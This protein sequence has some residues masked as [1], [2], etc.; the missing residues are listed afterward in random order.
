MSTT[1]LESFSMNKAL[2]GYLKKKQVIPSDEEV[3]RRLQA[4][5]ILQ[6]VANRWCMVCSQKHFGHKI[7]VSNCA[8]KIMTTGSYRLGAFN[9]GSDIDTV[10]VCPSHLSRTD[11]WDNFLPMLESHP[12]VKDITPVRD[13]KVPIIKCHIKDIDIDILQ[14]VTSMQYSTES[15]DVLDD[16]ILEAMDS[17][18]I[19]SINGVRHAEA[20]LKELPDLTRYQL[21]LRAVKQWAKARGILNNAMGYLNGV[22]CAIMAA[23]VAKDNPNAL[24][25]VLFA[26]FFKYWMDYDFTMPVRL[27]D[28]ESTAVCAVP[29][30]RV[31][32]SRPECMVVLTPIFPAFNS[33]LRTKASHLQLI[34]EEICRA[35]TILETLTRHSIGSVGKKKYKG[36]CKAVYSKVFKERKFF[37]CYKTFLQIS[38]PTEHSGLMESKM[39]TIV[40][41]LQKYVTPRYSAYDQFHPLSYG[42]ENPQANVPTMTYFVGLHIDKDEQ[43]KLIE[44]QA[45]VMLKQRLDITDALSRMRT[46]SEWMVFNVCENSSLPSFLE[47]N[48]E[49][50]PKYHSERAKEEEE[51]TVDEAQQ[52]KRTATQMEGDVHDSSAKQIKI[53]NNQVL[54]RPTISL[55][56]RTV[57]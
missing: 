43:K 6:T 57:S 39:A 19:L 38:I 36:L 35:N 11:F 3:N 20:I 53:E 16:N 51:A 32:I 15:I 52:K 5:R 50:N 7:H 48:I 28:T 18:C 4:L 29:E 23:V 46:E 10:I 30:W 56:T 55:I 1:T 21:L 9:P 12:E 42:I 2:E 41:N 40:D 17:T 47:V 33:M 25:S 8:V 24:P 26:K 27:C 13:A 37:F 45:N 49:E 14:A 22:S 31:N 54:A 34:Y 44:R